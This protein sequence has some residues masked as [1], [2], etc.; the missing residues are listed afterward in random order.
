M[1][2]IFLEENSYWGFSHLVTTTA[3]AAASFQT[4]TMYQSAYEVFHLQCLR[5]AQQASRMVKG[6]ASE[7][8]PA[9]SSPISTIEGLPLCDLGTSYYLCDLGHSSSLLWP[10]FTLLSGY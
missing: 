2:I 4:L 10:V 3:T 9:G 6:C 1:P 8:R 7:R 5:A